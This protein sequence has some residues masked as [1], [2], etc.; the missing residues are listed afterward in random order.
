MLFR[1]SRAA[2]RAGL[3]DYDS[4]ASVAPRLVLTADRRK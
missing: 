4:S 1:N 3:C 2:T